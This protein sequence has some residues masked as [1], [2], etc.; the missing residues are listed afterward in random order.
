MRAR[1]ALLDLCQVRRLVL[2]NGVD[3]RD[4]RG[5]VGAHHRDGGEAVLAGDHA[6]DG[7]EVGHGG[8]LPVLT[9]T[10]NETHSYTP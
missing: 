2:E 5:A 10:E 3:Q 9:T 7:I 8:S 4:V 6:P 1:E